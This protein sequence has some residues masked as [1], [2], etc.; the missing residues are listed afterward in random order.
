MNVIVENNTKPEAPKAA[1]YTGCI[2]QWNLID[3]Q[4][5]YNNT[6]ITWADVLQCKPN[7]NQDDGDCTTALYCSVCGKVDIAAQDSHSFTNFASNNDAT[8]MADGT[9]T[10]HCDTVGC[11]ATD[12]VTDD[13]SKKNHDFSKNAE[14][15][16]NGC[17]TKNPDYMPPLTPVRP[18]SPPAPTPRPDEPEKPDNPFIDVSRDDYFYDAVLWA[19][20][21]GITKGT[22]A[23]TFF[24]DDFCTRAQIV[25]FLYHYQQD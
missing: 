7:T 20:E 9:K 10:A 14:Y 13:G 23:T 4:Y 3:I 17:G 19:V 2:H 1:Y 12:T 8:C 6:K 21:D 15:C 24:S 22:S 16:R 18:T 5:T 11:T 25:T